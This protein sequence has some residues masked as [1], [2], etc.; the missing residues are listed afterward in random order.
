MQPRRRV[1]GTDYAPV[2]EAQCPFTHNGNTALM[3]RCGRR[4]VEAKNNCAAALLRALAQVGINEHTGNLLAQQLLSSS[5]HVTLSIDRSEATITDARGARSQAITEPLAGN[6]RPFRQTQDVHTPQNTQ[7]AQPPFPHTQNAQAPIPSFQIYAPPPHMFPS[8][9]LQGF[10]PLPLYL[11]PVVQQQPKLRPAS[12]G[13]P[14][15]Y[16]DTTKF[17][18]SNNRATQQ[19][20]RPRDPRLAGSDVNSKESIDEGEI[21]ERI[22]QERAAEPD[23]ADGLLQYNTSEVRNAKEKKN[24]SSEHITEVPM[25]QY[26]PSSSA[27]DT[28][29]R[30][31]CS[32]QKVL[33][34]C[35]IPFVVSSVERIA[36]GVDEQATDVFEAQLSLLFD[37]RNEVM[38][39][40]GESAA[41]AKRGSE[42]FLLKALNKVRVLGPKKHYDTCELLLSCWD[43]LL[44]T[45]ASAASDAEAYCGLTTPSR[46]VKA[47]PRLFES[48]G[49]P[50]TPPPLPDSEDEV[51]LNH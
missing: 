27:D 46:E 13:D 19:H 5:W 34:E 47:E 16:I 31:E 40:R 35:Q 45:A 22:E 3:V 9:P 33:E 11:Y 25:Q 10:N 1:G 49:E 18:P 36:S 50:N 24:V 26:E 15:L 6:K 48:S 38:R 7:A 17:L 14:T 23:A 28:S 20:T 44:A 30:K 4:K 51:E 39:Y 32:L 12:Y 37:G 42:A 21:V 8:P 29:K 41:D 43:D 2:F